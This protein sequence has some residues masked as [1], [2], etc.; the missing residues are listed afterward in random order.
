M[1]VA[2]RGV[3]RTFVVGLAWVVGCWLAT[4][5]SALP[6]ERHYE[7]V[8]P[9]Y[10][11]GYGVAAMEDVAVAG[12]GE[13]NRV[14]FE[15]FGSFV[16]APNNL[17]I[18]NSYLAI[19]SASEWSTTPVMLP[20]TPEM[21][22]GN[23]TASTRVSAS[24]ELALYEGA[25]TEHP[26]E[27]G[28]GTEEGPHRE[29]F[30][31][32]RLG[33]EGIPSEVLYQPLSAV[34]GQLPRLTPIGVSAD[35]CHA[36]FYS[37]SP[38]LVEAKG[39]N[40][41]LYELSA[42]QSASGCGGE[43]PSLHL[44]AV[45]GEGAPMNQYCPPVLG[46]ALKKVMSPNE[47]SANGDAFFTA[48]PNIGEG[49]CDG[50]TGYFPEGP[51]KLFV[52]LS[53]ERTVEMSQPLAVDC[54]GVCEAAP[55]QRAVFTGANEAGTRVFFTT[56]QPL[57]T[58]DREFECQQTVG[59]LEGF[60]GAFGE[61]ETRAECESNKG[62]TQEGGTWKRAGNDLYMAALECAGGGDACADTERE[63]TS[64]KQ[65][66]QSQISGEAAEVQGQEAVT[67][68]QDGE[69]VYF[70]ATG[71]LTA[72]ANAEG[73][74][75]IKG[76]DN[77]YVYDVSEGR[78]H[79]VVDLCSGAERSGAVVDQ[80]CPG[81]SDSEQW[82]G[83]RQAETTVNGE[84]L[85]FT[86]YGQLTADDTD[87]ARDIYSYDANTE[88]LERVSIGEDGAD[89]NGNN[90]GHNVE[91]PIMTNGGG[92]PEENYYMFNRGSSDDGSRIAFGTADPLS[93]KATNGLSNIYEWHD[94]TVSLVS[95]GVASGPEGDPTHQS[96]I[97]TPSGRD[98]FFT[99][100]QGLVPEDADG[101]NDVYD[102]RLGIGFP[103]A[104]DGRRPCEDGGC[105][106]PLMSPAPLL[107]PGSVSQVPG[108]NLVPKVAMRAKAKKRKV[109]RRPGHKPRRHA[110][111]GKKRRRG[112]R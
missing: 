81:K 20:A 112:G 79:F 78:N 63:V 105:Q 83:Q 68:S 23:A 94:G 32:Q 67:M 40:E 50:Q 57:T 15:S 44:V 92:V 30:A 82:L 87:T 38:L 70:V 88:T 4:G 17:L 96:V 25:L 10:K 102:A 6:V 107:V 75:P 84:F 58:T 77:L 55:P 65:V 95:S 101:V 7:R 27:D 100:S 108:E 35:L 89:Q 5:A 19:R 61:F 73:R 99:S 11:G 33:L 80:L 109:K 13:G 9:S 62:H 36:V 21:P 49:K 46:G 29:E 31:R 56:I 110:H 66:S 69:R 34:E 64:L 18:G 42:G 51:A 104:P 47:I 26:G 76:A 48:D 111:H 12:P 93:E 60:L 45:E 103:E 24:L 52:R 2:G 72:G 41:P 1:C 106:G 28:Q 59:R 91:L 3:W 90:S 97:I 37:K 86:S 39:L 8:S 22:Y 14:R 54:K 43:T 71:V 85:I 74:V 98:I 53:G 16:G